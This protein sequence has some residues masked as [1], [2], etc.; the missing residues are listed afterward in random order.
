MKIAGKKILITGASSGIG[1]ALAKELISREAKLALV[2]RSEERLD[3]ALIEI[4]TSYPRMPAPVSMVC[5]V[6]NR[7]SVSQLVEDCRKLLGDID[8]LINNAGIG[9]YGV[10]DKTSIEDFRSVMEVNFFGAI[11]CT[12]QMLPYMKSKGTGLIVNIASVAAMHGVPY[13]SAYSAS[14][15]A[16]VAFS[17][18]LRAELKDKRISI[19]IVYPGYTQTD[20]FKHEKKVGGARRPPGPYRPAKQV[21][22]AIVKAIE[23]DKEDVVLSIEGK[24]LSITKKLIPKLVDQAMQRIALQLQA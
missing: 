17:Q 9:V 13:L 20:F 7:E 10:T 12:L 22:Q 19:M 21:A 3:K 16:L 14:K 23:S 15:A 4:K 5:D 11:N 1:L 2:S 18:S 6:T 24:I 8:I